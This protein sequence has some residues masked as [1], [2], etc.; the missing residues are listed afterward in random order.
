MKKK[1]RFDLINVGVLVLFILVVAVFLMLVTHSFTGHTTVVDLTTST[2][3]EDTIGDPMQQVA[4]DYAT[5]MTYGEFRALESR[6]EEIAK[7]RELMNHGNSGE[8]ANFAFLGL[9]SLS[10]CDTC[11]TYSFSDPF[12]GS[13]QRHYLML[14]GYKLVGGYRNKYY[15]DNGRYWLKYPVW[16]TPQRGRYAL[17]ELPFRFTYGTEDQNYGYVKGSVL[18]PIS[19]KLYK[20]LYVPLIV[21]GIIVM[22]G[23][24]YIYFAI[25]AKILLRISRGE[26]FT[27][28]HVRQL[29]LIA[30]SML[31]LPFLI[32]VLQWLLRLIFHNNI[33][34]DVQLT[35]LSTLWSYKTMLIAGLI[36]LAI[37]KAFKRGLSLQTEQDLTV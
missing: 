19:K 10:E 21:L 8:S 1:F 13:V 16:D 23:L 18:I 9:S 27:P 17:K 35:I 22:I 4:P 29:H 15:V 31:G 12:S 25:P 11:T 34:S 32:V 30:I 7:R 33:T 6:A 36:F 20:L 14:P 28:Q 26:I 5:T 3:I 2:M 24:C 37:A